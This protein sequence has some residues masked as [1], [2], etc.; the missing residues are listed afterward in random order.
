MYRARWTPDKG[1]VGDVVP[2]GPLTLDP[3]AQVREQGH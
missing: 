1:Y 3:A 2:Y